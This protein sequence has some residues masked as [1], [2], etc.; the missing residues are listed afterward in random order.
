MRKDMEPLE[1]EPGMFRTHNSTVWF[2][3]YHPSDTEGQ[4]C[5]RHKNSH[6]VFPMLNIV[7]EIYNHEKI[8]C[9]DC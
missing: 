9:N 8:S 2:F 1:T 6:A 7:S 4:V 3:R 5:G